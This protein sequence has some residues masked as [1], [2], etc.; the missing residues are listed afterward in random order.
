MV[1]YTIVHSILHNRTLDFASQ[2][3]TTTREHSTSIF[4]GQMNT[5]NKHYTV[6]WSE[7]HKSWKMQEFNPD[8]EP[9]HSTDFREL[10]ES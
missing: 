4:C 6:G 1:F 5:S 2:K 3:H 9:R 10:L 7:K 8:S